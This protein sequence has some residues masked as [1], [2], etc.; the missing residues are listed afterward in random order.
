VTDY[1]ELWV[2]GGRERIPLE[3]ERVTIGQAATNEVAL[4]FDRTVSRL[5]AVL[6]LVKS[7]WCV[8]DLGSRNGTFVN[9]EQ[10]HEAT[11]VAKG[12][13]VQVGETVLEVER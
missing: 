1:L 12:T 13:R 6:E 4:P 2:D 7:D 5:H 3:G 8:R 10:V 11:K 9:G